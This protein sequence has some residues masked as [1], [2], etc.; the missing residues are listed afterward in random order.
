[1]SART[2][3]STFAATI[4]QLARD[5]RYPAQSDVVPR[6]ITRA[7]ELVS[8]VHR[9]AIAIARDACVLLYATIRR[10]AHTLG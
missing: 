5:V 2:L 6:T 1:M 3:A 7:R 10:A 4:A 8:A 9:A